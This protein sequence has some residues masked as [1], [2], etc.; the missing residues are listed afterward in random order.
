MA[1]QKLQSQYGVVE[2]NH[3]AAVKT[4]QIYA[5]YT[6]DP[7]GFT[8]S[9]YGENGMLVSVDHVAKLVKL[10]SGA[11]ASNIGLLATVSKEYEGKGRKYFAIKPG[12][13]N[14]RVLKLQTGDIF[15]TNAVIYDDTVYA[16]YNAIVA[17]NNATT[18]YGVPD[19]TG[20]IKIIA[21]L[22]GTEKNALKVV[23]GVTL[24]NGERGF[25][26][27]VALVG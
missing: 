18:V 19:A 8:G 6:L 23:E 14:P 25:K 24:P 17:A 3:V 21:T 7:A 20:Y 4:G 12:E 13:F 5:Q 26:F 27:V 15:E 22:A 9:K 10:P 2:T 11:T 1:I 16:D